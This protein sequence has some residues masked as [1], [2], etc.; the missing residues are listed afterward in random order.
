MKDNGEYHGLYMGHVRDAGDPESRGR[1]RLF[2]PEVMGQ[3]DDTDHW[4]DWALPCFPW[5]AHRGVGNMLVPQ[6]DSGLGVWVTFRHGNVRFPV[7][8]GVFVI[9]PTKVDSTIAKLDAQTIMLGGDAITAP[10]ASEGVVVGLGQDPFT[11]ATYAALGNAS[12]R[13]F[14]KKV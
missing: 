13:V 7:W 10:A 14:A 4:T 6:P 3:L 8:M 5:F 9:D 1:I 12:T 11:G 2:V